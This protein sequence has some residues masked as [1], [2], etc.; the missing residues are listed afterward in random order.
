MARP[1]LTTQLTID[2]PLSQKG[3]IYTSEHDYSLTSSRL[4]RRR[5]SSEPVAILGAIHNK[6]T[7]A[8]GSSGR[9]A[10]PASR[11]NEVHP[12][13]V[14]PKTGPSQRNRVFHTVKLGDTLEGIAVLYGMSVAD[15]KRLNKIWNADEIFL[16]GAVEVIPGNQADRENDESGR[17]APMSAAQAQAVLIAAAAQNQ[18]TGR[19][20]L[21]SGNDHSE[22]SSIPPPST[23]PESSSVSQLLNQLDADVKS[24]LTV[25]EAS[26]TTAAA[27]KEKELPPVPSLYMY[28]PA[29]ASPAQRPAKPQT[30]TSSPAS[31]TASP[32]YTPKSAR[33]TKIRPNG[34]PA[35]PDVDLSARAAEVTV[36]KRG[37]GNKGET[38]K[39]VEWEDT[40]MHQ[41]IDMQALCVD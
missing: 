3:A 18:N 19:K 1:T 5:C 30:H 25:F 17:K 22:M 38:R 40:E 28:P 2:H 21:S 41:L 8:K 37:P 7:G 23:P 31:V 16:K 20:Q 15:I 11:M 14:P 39:K 4:S 12:P 6:L 24:A 35:V 34:L 29:P 27:R 26:S 10:A 36:E 33:R 32:N 13:P 9:N